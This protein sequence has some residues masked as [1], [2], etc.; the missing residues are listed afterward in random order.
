MVMRSV[1]LLVLVAATGYV[2][3]VVVKSVDGSDRKEG[4]GWRVPA[5][6]H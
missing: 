2:V 1:L 6:P 4:K 5:W 3:G